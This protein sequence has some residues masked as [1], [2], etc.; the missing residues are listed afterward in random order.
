MKRNLR[1]PGP[2]PLPV[3]VRKALS[4]QVINHRGSEFARLLIDT[5]EKLKTVFQTKNDVLIFPAAGTGAMEAAIVNLFSAGDRVLSISIG[6]FGNRFAEIGTIFGLELVSLQ[7]PLGTAADPGKIK[8]ILNKI[9]GIKGVIL[10][11]NETST[12]VTNELMTIAKIVKERGLLFIVDAE[13]SL[14][15][16]EVKTDEWKLDVVLAGS[17]KGWMAPPGLAMISISPF[18]WEAVKKAR[19]PR[20]YWDFERAKDYY[21]K[22]QTPYTPAVSTFF[23]LQE[24]LN[25]ILE[26]GLDNV[27]KRHKEIAGLTRTEVKKIGLTLFA[28]ERSASNAVTAVNMPRGV[29]AKKFFKMLKEQYG[30]E[31]AGGQG[32]LSGKIFRI[33]HLGHV[34]HKEILAAIRAVNKSLRDIR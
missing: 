30:V 32:E 12:G 24:G 20:Y 19:L 16:I 34:T 21:K 4:K 13:S 14:A 26:E 15:A 8:K 22:G 28:D 31:L 5:T 17:Q 7:F 18:A 9:K 27:F 6:T 1:I 29:D 25:I 33:G 10:T 23:A 3:R 2:T 11:H